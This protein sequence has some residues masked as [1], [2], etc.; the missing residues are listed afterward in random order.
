MIRSSWRRHQSASSGTIDI[1]SYLRDNAMA[2]NRI[3]QDRISTDVDW[4]GGKLSPLWDGK[5]VA[6]SM[7]LAKGT[8]KRKNPLIVITPGPSIG[9]PRRTVIVSV[10][11]NG[12][13]IVEIDCN[14]T[15]QLVLAGI[16]AK[17]AKLLL[18]KLRSTYREATN[19]NRTTTHRPHYSTRARRWT[20]S[21][22]STVS[23]VRCTTPDSSSGSS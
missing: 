23:T 9:L 1:T 13:C 12:S 5:T 6:F 18:E 20:S 10:I 21:R 22:K 11:N 3:H 16:P 19:G 8:G 7:L 14:S 15:L 2:M 17:L 4:I